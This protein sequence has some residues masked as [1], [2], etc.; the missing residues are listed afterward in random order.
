MG[1][2]PYLRL[3]CVSCMNWL[4]GRHKFVPYG[5][6]IRGPRLPLSASHHRRCEGEILPVYRSRHRRGC[7]GALPP[8]A[9]RAS[10]RERR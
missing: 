3:L 10:G 1:A 4:P 8:D 7:Q 6:L 5:A 9:Y 2:V